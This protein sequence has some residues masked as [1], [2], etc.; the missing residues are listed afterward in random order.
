MDDRLPRPATA[1]PH[2]R[3]LCVNDV[4]KPERL[5]QFRT[6]SLASRAQLAG[7][8]VTKHV[9][10]GDFLGGSVF[11]AGHEGA[12][13]VDVLN[14]LEIDYF[15]H[16]NHEFDFGAERVAELM[17]QSTFPWLGSNVRHADTKEL[18]HKTLDVDTFDVPVISSSSAS[19]AVKVGVFGVCTECTP[20]L[21]D[22]GD[23]VV[24][25]D[26]VAHAARCIALLRGP[27]H[28]CDV[29]VGLTHVELPV[30]RSIAALPGVDIIVGGHEVRATT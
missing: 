28:A 25:E 12:S 13:V 23:S 16:G 9:F 15:T 21:A 10:P 1:A 27:A 8:T 17:D 18:F 11:A 3:L 24:F 19:R 20:S 2:L 7:T 30:D 14:Q 4:Y 26:P 6:L 5:S 29:V 22:P